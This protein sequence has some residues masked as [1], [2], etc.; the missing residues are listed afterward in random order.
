MSHKQG[1]K[2]HLAHTKLD[3][4]NDAFVT[5]NNTHVRKYTFKSIVVQ[6]AY[7]LRIYVNMLI[8]K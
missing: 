5:D 2:S 4:S 1:Q 8:V 7:A 6:C 3:T